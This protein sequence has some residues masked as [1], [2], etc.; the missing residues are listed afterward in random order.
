VMLIAPFS[1]ILLFS[2][3]ELRYHVKYFGL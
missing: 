1:L 2:N 3:F